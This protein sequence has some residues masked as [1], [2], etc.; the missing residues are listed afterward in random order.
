MGKKFTQANRPLAVKVQGL[1]ADALL[2]VGFTGEEAVSTPFHFRLDLVAENPARINFEQV[3][4][5]AV[6][7]ELELPGSPRPREKK[8]VFNGICQRVTQGETDD[9]FTH[10][11]M[12]V[13]PS[14]WLLTKRARSRVFQHQMVSSIIERVL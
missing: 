9:L 10:Y 4:G 7:V 14:L 3:L 6:T 1:D 2:L 12:D 11:Q 5:K 8:R 13:V